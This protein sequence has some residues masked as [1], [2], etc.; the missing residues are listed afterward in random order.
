MI[1][2]KEQ[3]M[4]V[5]S[6]MESRDIEKISMFF[7]EAVVFEDPRTGSTLYGRDMVLER[8]QMLFSFVKK[9]KWDIKKIAIDG[10]I[11]FIEQSKYRNYSRSGYFSPHGNNN[12]FLSFRRSSN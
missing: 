7:D 5:V 8:F 9:I 10:P 4:K 1:V 12:D 3:V 6:A 2:N 11:V